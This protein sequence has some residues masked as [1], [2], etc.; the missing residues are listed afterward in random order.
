M[1][2]A[3]LTRTTHLHISI[4]CVFNIATLCYLK[5][6]L[7]VYFW[8]S[9]QPYRWLKMFVC[10]FLELTSAFKSKIVFFFVHG[11]ALHDSFFNF[12]QIRNLCIFWYF[13]CNKT[14]PK[15][16]STDSINCERI[17]RISEDVQWNCGN[18]SRYISI[19]YFVFVFF[20]FL[21]FSFLLLL[22]PV[23]YYCY[24]ISL[25]TLAFSMKRPQPFHARE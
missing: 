10:L 25:F 15:L 4:Q 18:Y 23:C 3:I 6:I 16:L 12:S 21:F 20:S 8:F 17:L 2:G 19:L 9:L 22:M 24:Y 11:Y 5:R 7:N 1:L 13:I 14:F